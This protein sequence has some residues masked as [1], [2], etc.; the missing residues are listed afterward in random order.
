MVKL[1]LSA[2]F[3]QAFQMAGG[4]LTASPRV[5]AELDGDS[6]VCHARDT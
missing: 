3:P 5:V 4:S 1:S 6:S 2:T